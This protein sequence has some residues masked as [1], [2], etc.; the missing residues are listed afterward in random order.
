MAVSMVLDSWAPLAS[1]LAL[2]DLATVDSLTIMVSI[3]PVFMD[4]GSI[5]V[6]GTVV[7]GTVVVVADT[8]ELKAAFALVHEY[9][10][11]CVLPFVARFI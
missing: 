6:V 3:P 8:A 9:P 11:R 10:S 1:V 5:A 2:T 7:V 4:A